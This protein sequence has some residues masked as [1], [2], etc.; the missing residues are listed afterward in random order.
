LTVTAGSSIAMGINAAPVDSDDT[1][2]VRISG[3]PRFET[4]TAPSGDIV[5][6]KRNGNTYTYTI[7][8]PTGQAV[9]GLTLNSS[10][11]GTG[12]PVNVL[13][14]TATNSTPGETGTSA[15][16]TIKVTDPPAPTLTLADAPLHKLDTSPQFTGQVS[17]GQAL[18][19]FA[20]VAF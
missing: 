14:V 3:V 15:P 1:I 13:T 17:G 2:S 18:L 4:I 8:A 19:G 10:Y 11:T 12:H 20:D 7:T 9:S 16:Q 5:T 6:S